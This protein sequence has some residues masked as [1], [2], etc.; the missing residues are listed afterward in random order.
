LGGLVFLCFTAAKR[1]RRAR[2]EALEEKF[3]EVS[4]FADPSGPLTHNR[5]YSGS[6]D[7]SSTQLHRDPMSVA[8]QHP[9]IF[10]GSTDTAFYGGSDDSHQQSMQE[11]RLHPSLAH[12]PTNVYL[13][14]ALTDVPSKSPS[15][16]RNHQSGRPSPDNMAGLGAEPR[17]TPPP[18]GSSQSHVPYSDDHTQKEDENPFLGGRPFDATRDS[19]SY[20]PSLDSFYVAQ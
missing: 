8:N 18:A 19:I 13:P 20:Q 9:D 15:P 4:P 11:H 7:F 12:T 10:Y 2:N 16:T 1:A 17:K 14:A 6:S 5:S 3:V